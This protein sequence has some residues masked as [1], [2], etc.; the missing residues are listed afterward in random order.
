[1]A[2]TRASSLP[3]ARDEGACAPQ[4]K[5]AESLVFIRVH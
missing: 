2:M 1:L 4:T 5:S 3:Q